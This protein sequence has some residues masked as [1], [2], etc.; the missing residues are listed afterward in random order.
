MKQLDARLIKLLASNENYAVAEQLLAT[1]KPI[2]K[3]AKDERVLADVKVNNEVFHVVI[4]KNE[5]RNL[6][7]SCPCDTEI[8]HPLCI[9]KTIVLL[10]LY[11]AHGANYFDSIRNWD[12]EKNKLLSLYGYSLD[13][14]IKNKFE[15]VY[16]DGKPFLRVLDA[17]IKRVVQ[18]A[19]PVARPVLENVTDEPGRNSGRQICKAWYCNQLQS[20]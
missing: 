11:K 14:D 16:K 15:F 2:I 17:S 13:D 9:H 6:D 1:S 4:Q 18:A 8:K 7:T 20:A 3:E 19:V 12:K 5:E 10:Y